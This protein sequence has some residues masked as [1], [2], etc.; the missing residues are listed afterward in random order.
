MI[1]LR[2]LL[3]KRLPNHLEELTLIDCHMNSSLVFRL[4]EMIIDTKCQ[5][6]KL[7]LVNANHSES[8]FGKIIEFLRES[9]YLEELDL[10]W[11]KMRVEQWIKFLE[12][13]KDNRK[14]VYL[15]ISY[16]TIQEAQPEPDNDEPM[17]NDSWLLNERNKSILKNLKQFIKYNLNL[18]TLNLDNTALQP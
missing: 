6:R 8:S 2:P 10:S 18:V 1:H 13:I 4:M 14:L 9:D 11:S 7:G 15:N 17:S 12:V 5:L 16:N 3:M